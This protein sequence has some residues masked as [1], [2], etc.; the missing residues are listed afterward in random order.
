MKKYRTLLNMRNKKSCQNERLKE[1]RYFNN[2]NNNMK[3]YIMN[4]LLLTST[5][6]RVAA[7]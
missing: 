4:L 7:D 5:Y 2:L 3:T 1:S 6:P